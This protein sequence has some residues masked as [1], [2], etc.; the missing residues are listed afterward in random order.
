M[1]F[2]QQDADDVRQVI[3]MIKR[4]NKEP[5][6]YRL[7]DLADRLEREANRYVVVSTTK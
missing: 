3:G 5:L 7:D 1:G 6:E 4:I 2:T